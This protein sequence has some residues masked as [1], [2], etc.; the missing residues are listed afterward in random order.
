LN[1]LNPITTGN[2][3]IQRLTIQHL[4]KQYTEKWLNLL[5]TLPSNSASSETSNPRQIP[6]KKIKSTIIEPDI[7]RI[8]NKARSTEYRP[9]MN[10]NFYKLFGYIRVIR[11]LFS[12]LELFRNFSF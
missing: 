3:Y 10:A 11:G 12:L 9:R 2:G 6:L 4:L 5:S 8:V 7:H 1:T